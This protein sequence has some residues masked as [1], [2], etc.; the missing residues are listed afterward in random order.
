LTCTGT[1][2][3][4]DSRLMVKVSEPLSATR[5]KAQAY[6]RGECSA[7]PRMETLFV[8]DAEVTGLGL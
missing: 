8:G 1:I 5:K 2:H 4:A 7:D 3:K 6:W